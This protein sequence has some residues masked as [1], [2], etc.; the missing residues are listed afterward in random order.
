MQEIEG[1]SGVRL[2]RYA[3]P[4]GGYS[5][6]IELEHIPYSKSYMIRLFAMAYL[7]GEMQ[8]LE[9]W[10]S[11]SRSCDDI[12]DM[13]EALL[14]LGE[15]NSPHLYV[16]SAGAVW[17]FMTAIASL[18]TKRPIRFLGGLRLFDRPIKPLIEALKSLGA[19]IEF[20]EQEASAMTIFPSSSPLQG[21]YIGS[22]TGIV[23]SQFL[24][25]LL[26]IAPYLSSPLSVAAPQSQ[27]SRAYVE[28]TCRLMERAG[29]KVTLTDHEAHVEP[30]SYNSQKVRALL[31][32]PETDWTAVSYPLSWCA[33]TKGPKSLFIPNC[34]RESVQGDIAV[35]KFM[36]S[37]GVKTRFFPKGLL[38]ERV[39]CDNTAIRTFEQDLSDNIDLVPTLFATALATGRPFRFR[40][41]GALRYKESDRFSSL[42]AMAKSLGY[43]VTATEEEL[44]WNGQRT[45]ISQEPPL[46]D[47]FHDHRI[48]M[49]ASL[50]AIER[51]EILLQN[52]NVVEKSY[53]HF[54]EDMSLIGIELAN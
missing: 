2:V 52:P 4:E 38:I 9:A 16:G 53:S 44:A 25:A 43:Q 15:T 17:R 27:R 39:P 42:L 45:P 8:G 19:T 46:I 14:A 22:E 34:Y 47:P 12:D 24:S 29:A 7:C 33:L 6:T 10:R 5:S 21:G 30:S 23:S 35:T 20:N 40:R 26:L 41:V 48:A 3:P 18:T 13:R 54:W 37:F 32:K 36:E 31:E 1:T 50:F 28:L 51:G 49:A 11:D